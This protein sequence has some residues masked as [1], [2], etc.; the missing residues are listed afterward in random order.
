M[1]TP[2]SPPTEKEIRAYERM[3]EKAV[4]R[5]QIV[6]SKEFKRTKYVANGLLCFMCVAFVFA[7]WIFMVA[8]TIV[9]AFYLGWVTF[10]LIV[11]IKVY[12]DALSRY[13]IAD[14]L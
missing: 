8:P 4:T 11:N 7:F 5:R 12:H 6:T 14:P 3:Y 10:L 2:I 9:S 1:T 13:A